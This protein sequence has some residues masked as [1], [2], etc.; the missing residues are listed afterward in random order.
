MLEKIKTPAPIVKNSQSQ[1]PETTAEKEENQEFELF[2]ALVRQFPPTIDHAS[3]EVWKNFQERI[4]T[5]NSPQT[6]GSTDTTEVLKPM[7]K[8]SHRK[9]KWKKFHL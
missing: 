9:S 1:I 4:P 2:P 3:V 6:F 7:Q 5:R 8:E